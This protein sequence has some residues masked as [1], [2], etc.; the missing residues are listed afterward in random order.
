M[1]KSIRVKTSF[2][3]HL[4]STAE[5]CRLAHST[6][7]TLSDDVLL[8]IFDSCRRESFR[9]IDSRNGPDTWLW[10]DLVH[11]CR[12]WRCIVFAFPGY[13]GLGL[14]CKSKTHMQAALEIWPALPHSVCICANLNGKGTDEDDIIGALEHRDHVAGISL[15][16]LKR[17][18]LNKCIALLQEP[19]PVLR[20]L[21]LEA[22]QR[23]KIV[24]PDA[25]L[26]VSAPLLR[27]ISLRGI[28]FQTK[29][30]S[31]IHDLFYLELED[32]PT[33]GKGHISPDAMTTCL[34]PLTKLQSLTISFLRQTSSPYITDQNPPPSTHIVLPAL[35]YLSLFGPY[36]YLDYLVGRV[37]AP[38]LNYGSLSF[39]DEYLLDTPRL[40]QFIHRT[41]ISKL[42]GQV[43]VYVISEY[44]VAIFRSSIGPALFYLEFRGSGLPAQLAIMVHL[45]AHQPP[46]FSHAESLQLFVL[47]KEKGWWE[48]LT[49]WLGLLRLF[50][51]VHTLRLFAGAT[52]SYTAHVL[53]E[54][55]GERATEVLPALRT[56]ELVCC[57]SESVVSE[58]LCLLKPFLFAR[59]ESEHPVE[60]RAESKA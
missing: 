31:S 26:G 17:S 44:I 46:L 20:S 6:I 2:V 1:T 38:L 54:F 51:A 36:G 43:E 4:L 47:P 48:V 55:G 40:P 58:S 16:G 57:D 9:K 15:W 37:D 24:L 18:Q 45:S 5:G 39:D 19:F 33:T 21:S 22:D 28:R 12:R 32:I 60:V 34:S 49:P 7:D 14:K 59:D 42:L 23:A 56:I 29:L 11:V 8:C 27:W 3:Q 10:Y 53:G 35:T 52:V 25:F 13:L 50:T 41:K 30:L